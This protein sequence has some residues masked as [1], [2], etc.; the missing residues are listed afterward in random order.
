MMENYSPGPTPGMSPAV[1]H[2]CRRIFLTG[3]TGVLGAHILKTL[4]AESN[5][6]LFCLVR[7]ATLEQGRDRLL[8]FLRTY[9]PEE[10]LKASFMARVTP[11]LGDVTQD[12]L[13]LSEADYHALADQVEATI[14]AA[15]STN[16]FLS[17]RRTEPI[18][19]GGTRRMIE[20]VLQTRSKYLCYISTY[21]V[22]GDK[23]FDPTFRFHEHQ[24][25]VGQ[26]FAHMAYQQSKFIAENMLREA[27]SRGLQWNVMRPGQVFGETETGFYPNGQ[28]NVS[29]L[30]L[31]IFK[32]V[33][34]TGVAF[35][36]ETHFDVCPVDFVS[37]AVIHLGLERADRFQ[38]YHLLNPEPK[39]Y[40]QVV[41][42]IRNLGY[43]IQH[44]HQDEYRRLLF[45]GGLTAANL[46]S[47]APDPLGLCPEYKSATTKG[48]RWWF[49]R[50]PFDFSQSAVTDCSWTY[51]ILKAEGITCPPMDEKLIGTYVTAGVRAGYFPE[52]LGG[53]APAPAAANAGGAAR[54]L[55]AEV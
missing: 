31:D 6:R 45:E 19:V 8:S 17:F 35:R 12:R 26:G 48:F 9:D 14:H 34:E 54:F 22:M 5:D 44:V 43:P 37:K 39:T 53:E 7:A 28:T 24:L 11:V 4:L 52:A 29:G 41:N 18:N 46:R 30:F 49:Q 25:D 1:S 40:T 38:T 55:R 32:T 23:V 33:I 27:Q 36:S 10:K 47:S 50:D 15:A 2:D 16:L 51:D 20:F 21:T 42:A 3:A 13:G